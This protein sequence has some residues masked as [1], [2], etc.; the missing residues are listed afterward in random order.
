M[1]ESPSR[2][3]IETGTHDSTYRSDESTGYI[4]IKNQSPSFVS[5]YV[6]YE[7]AGLV[8]YKSKCVLA[9]ILEARVLCIHR[10]ACHYLKP[11][12]LLHRNIKPDI[13]QSLTLGTDY[14]WLYLKR[15]PFLFLSVLAYRHKAEQANPRLS[16][17]DVSVISQP[18][19]NRHISGS[20]RVYW[21]GP[22]VAVR[23]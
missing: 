11:H 21:T 8:I 17:G 22:H 12:A 2:S 1:S 14:P 20:R 5:Q 19:V 9:R 3:N 4:F 23:V 13:L 15:N 16:R 10:E 7:R 18:P 6:P